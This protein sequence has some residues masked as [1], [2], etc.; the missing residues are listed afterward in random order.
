MFQSLT[1]LHTAYL[2]KNLQS[3]RE[4]PMAGQNRIKAGKDKKGKNRH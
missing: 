3:F 1:Q 4:A 2:L